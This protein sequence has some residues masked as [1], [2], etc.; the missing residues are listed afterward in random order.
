M[1]TFECQH[2]LSEITADIEY[3]N[4]FRE[5]TPVTISTTIN[6]DASKLRFRKQRVLSSN[7]RVFIPNITFLS[8]EV[9]T[10]KFS[11]VKY[12]AAL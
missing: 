1:F 7:F 11:A 10:L 4:D 3:R 6:G 8:T 12:R 2:F 5:Q 9:H